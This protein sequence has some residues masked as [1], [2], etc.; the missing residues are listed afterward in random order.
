MTITSIFNS[1][2]DRAIAEHDVLYRTSNKLA[3]W[4]FE[5]SFYAFSLAEGYVVV[6]ILVLKKRKAAQPWC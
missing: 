6:R 1:R 3:A 4:R 2:R 5:G